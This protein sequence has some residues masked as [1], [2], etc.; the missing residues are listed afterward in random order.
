VRIDRREQ[1]RRTVIGG[2]ALVLGAAA[3]ALLLA[4]SAVGILRS[5]GIGPALVIGGL[6]TVSQL[7]ILF[8]AAVRALLV[9]LDPLAVPLIVLMFSCFLGALALTGLWVTAIRKLRT[10]RW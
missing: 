9:L 7:L 2:L 3:L 1:A 10:G 6:E 5:L 4:P 8:D